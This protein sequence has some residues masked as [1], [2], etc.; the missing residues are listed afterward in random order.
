LQ[1]DFGIGLPDW[2]DGLDRVLDELARAG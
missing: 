1:R 2:H